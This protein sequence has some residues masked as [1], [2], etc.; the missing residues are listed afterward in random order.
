M[1][2][3]GSVRAV[4][5]YFIRRSCISCFISSGS[6]TGPPSFLETRT[7]YR[8]IAAPDVAVPVAAAA[9][10]RGEVLHGGLAA[11][12][13][14]CPPCAA[15]DRAW[16]GRAD[17]GRDARHRT[18]ARRSRGLFVCGGIAHPERARVAAVRATTSRCRR[19]SSAAPHPLSAR[20]ARSRGWRRCSASIRPRCL[21]MRGSCMGTCRSRA[22]ST[23]SSAAADS[24]RSTYPRSNNW[25][26]DCR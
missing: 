16:S 1:S 10:R 19:R 23:R 6:V 8:Q 9:V 21:P 13:R 20:A 17:A 12:D 24:R 11:A 18:D 15:I 26:W 5:G 14:P 25:G 4:H 2:S 3:N 22:A 7:R